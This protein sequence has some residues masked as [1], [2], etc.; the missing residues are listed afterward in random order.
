[1]SAVVEHVENRKVLAAAPHG[2]AVDRRGWRTQGRH[3]LAD[4]RISGGPVEAAK[5]GAGGLEI[6]PDLQFNSTQCLEV[7]AGNVHAQH[8]HRMN[9]VD[10]WM[11][12]R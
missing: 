11:R 3:G 7:L 4:A 6:V 8:P 10:P 12:L 2:L 1:M 5:R 9:A